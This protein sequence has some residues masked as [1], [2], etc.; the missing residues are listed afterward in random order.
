MK[1]KDPNLLGKKIAIKFNNIE[2]NA[3]GFQVNEIN[4]IINNIMLKNS[5]TYIDEDNKELKSSIKDFNS[6]RYIRREEDVE[7][8]DIKDVMKGAKLPRVTTD[9]M[10][11]G[12]NQSLIFINE[13]DQTFLVR[14]LKD[15]TLHRTEAVIETIPAELYKDGIIDYDIAINIYNDM[16][17]YALPESLTLISDSNDIISCPFCRTKMTIKDAI[18]K[19]EKMSNEEKCPVCGGEVEKT[20]SQDGQKT[21]CKEHDCLNKIKL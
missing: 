5:V 3:T 17:K 2:L 12:C 8:Y 9:F 16:V 19:F 10:C 11:I 21:V 13:S 6:E 14:D 15:N 20:I 4:E 7:E 18:K 1:E